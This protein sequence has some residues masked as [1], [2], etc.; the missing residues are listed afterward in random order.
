MVVS[1]L[2][3]MFSLVRLSGNHKSRGPL[4]WLGHTSPLPCPAGCVTLRQPEC[5]ESSQITKRHGILRYKAYPS[6]FHGTHG[7]FV[8]YV[9]V[10]V[11]LAPP[12]SL[13]ECYYL[14]NTLP[15]TKNTQC[16]QTC[17][18]CLAFL[19]NIVILPKV[20]VSYFCTQ[21]RDSYTSTNPHVK[22]W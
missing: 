10:C 6:N 16:F 17:V 13:A 15:L 7:M 8:E 3:A 11:P 20:H 19:P 22:V 1:I 14:L 4:I 2:N 18:L 9:A 12:S 21:W 5:S